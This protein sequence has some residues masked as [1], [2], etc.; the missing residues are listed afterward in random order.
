MGQKCIKR[1][2]LPLCCLNSTYYL[3][4]ISVIIFSINE[5]KVQ[6][7]NATEVDANSAYDIKERLNRDLT[8]IA[9]VI[10]VCISVGQTD[11][12]LVLVI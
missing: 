11:F 1:R 6:E 12:V 10:G 9:T 8:C 2:K 7:P 4:F 5:S 3:G